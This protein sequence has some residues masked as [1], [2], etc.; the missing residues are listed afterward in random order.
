[1]GNI[2]Q[3]TVSDPSFPFGY[4]QTQFNLCLDVPVLKDNLNSICEKVDD[5]GFQTIILKKLNEV[6]VVGA[7]WGGL[8]CYWLLSMI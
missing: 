2:T 7:M 1:M 3:V 4:D 8:K 5:D 6:H